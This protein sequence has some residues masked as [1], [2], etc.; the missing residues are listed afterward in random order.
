MLARC[1]I[2]RKANT[3]W[4]VK[5]L[6]V[7]EKN[8][9]C[10]R[11]HMWNVLERIFEETPPAESLPDLFPSLPHLEVACFIPDLVRGFLEL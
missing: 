11:A 9:Q 4:F 6:S 8:K 1:W 10:E 3:I 7:A 5:E 2:A